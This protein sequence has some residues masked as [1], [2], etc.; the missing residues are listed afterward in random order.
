MDSSFLSGEKKVARA[1]L[2]LA[3]K[4]ILERAAIQ[5]YS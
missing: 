3:A 1:S 4:N 2:G 5:R